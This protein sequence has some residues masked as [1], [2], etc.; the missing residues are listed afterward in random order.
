MW[1]N[2]YI[3]TDGDLQ[4]SPECSVVPWCVNDLL[5]FYY[6]CLKSLLW[7]FYLAKIKD[8]IHFIKILIFLQIRNHIQW[9]TWVGGWRLH[10]PCFLRHNIYSKCIHNLKVNCVNFSDTCGGFQLLPFQF[11]CHLYQGWLKPRDPHGNEI[12]ENFFFILSDSF[13]L[14]FGHF[15]SIFSQ[16]V[17]A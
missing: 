11:A 15:H 3:N 4:D 10:L 9:L 16:L 17:K 8:S 13:N 1:L 12:I 6:T 2:T 5:V 14:F 7:G